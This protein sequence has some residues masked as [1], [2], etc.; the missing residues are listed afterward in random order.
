MEFNCYLSKIA[1]RFIKSCHACEV[2]ESSAKCSRLG[3]GGYFINVKNAHVCY[4]NFDIVRIF[5]KV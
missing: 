1:F 3:G 4:I 5:H 2:L